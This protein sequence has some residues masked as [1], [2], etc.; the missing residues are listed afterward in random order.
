MRKATGD[1]NP[2]LRGTGMNYFFIQAAQ[3]LSEPGSWWVLN[4]QSCD[5]INKLEKPD[6]FFSKV[7]SSNTYIFY[8]VKIPRDICPTPTD[9]FLNLN[10]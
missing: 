9:D 1:S 10:H 2:G 7:T 6:T 5:E 8:K 3:S 4:Q